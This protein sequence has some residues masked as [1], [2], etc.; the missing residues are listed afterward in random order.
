MTD[1]MPLK[2]YDIFEF[3][4]GESLLQLSGTTQRTGADDTTQ[5]HRGLTEFSFRLQ[6]KNSHGEMS[7]LFDCTFFLVECL[8]FSPRFSGGGPQ[9]RGAFLF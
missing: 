8:E 3:K 6:R 2:G 1:D 4:V 9:H 7:N 5:Y